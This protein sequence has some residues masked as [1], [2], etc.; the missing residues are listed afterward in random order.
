MEEPSELTACLASDTDN[1]IDLPPITFTARDNSFSFEAE[2]GAT[3]DDWG[4]LADACDNE[5]PAAEIDWAPA[6]GDAKI[7][8]SNKIV[9]FVIGKTGDGRGGF[10]RVKLSASQRVKGF[11]EAERL[12]R[13][14]KFCF[15]LA[16]PGSTEIFN[17]D[18]SQQRPKRFV[19]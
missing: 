17:E 11:R 8:V 4:R 1:E 15:L 16:E 3:A 6:N 2:E 5:R 18:V 9:M 19:E 7:I 10:L 14:I 12:T 13:L